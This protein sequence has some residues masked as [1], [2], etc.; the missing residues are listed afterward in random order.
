M[1]TTSPILRVDW[2]QPG[3]ATLPTVLAFTGFGHR[4][5]PWRRMRPPGW[6]LGVIEFPVNRAPDDP[7]TIATLMPQ[8]D[9]LWR[10]APARALLSFSFG[11]APATAVANAIAAAPDKFAPPDL[12][13]Y[14]APVQWSRI[15]WPAI[16]AI[17][18]RKRLWALKNFARGGAAM[19]G[20]IAAKLG[21]PA[22]RDFVNIVDRYVGW[23]FVAFYLPYLDWIRS[24]K[25]TLTDWERH[26]WPTHLFGASDDRVIPSVGMATQ[27]ASFA[28]GVTFHQ[29]TGVHYNALDMAR[30]A[31][32]SALRGLLAADSTTLRLLSK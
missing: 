5:D 27:V 29:T 22:V 18:A 1:S 11:G 16:R 17:P 13:A 4:L 8:I 12:A 26:V 31:I 24:T 23:D 25:S 28:P 19:L 10:E 3:P 21:N 15:P 9:A 32:L 2:V 20:P 7:W 30:P 6:R 14:V